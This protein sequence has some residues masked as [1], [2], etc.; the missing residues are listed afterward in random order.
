MDTALELVKRIKTKCY[1]LQKLIENRPIDVK[2]FQDIAVDIE[3]IE[4]TL[5]ELK[6]LLSFFEEVEMRN[7]WR[8][9]CGGEMIY[10][11]KKMTNLLTLKNI[12]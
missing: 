7:V 1:L 12:N 11:H 2:L 9:E 10:K 6:G 5:S 8:S 3:Q 4:K